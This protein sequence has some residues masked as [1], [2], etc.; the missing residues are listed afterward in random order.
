MKLEFLGVRNFFTKQDYHNNLLVDDHILIDCGFSAARSLAETG[1]S[2]ADVDSIFITHTHADHIGGLEEC[3]FFN[4][5]VNGGTRPRLFLPEALIPDLWKNSLSGGLANPGSGAPGID[6]YFDIQPVL[7]SFSTGGLNF[8][9][10]P[11]SHVPDK[12]CCGLM[13]ED[14]GYFSGDTQFAPETIQEYGNRAMAVF[15]E[16]EFAGGIV[17]ALRDDLVTVSEDIRQETWLMHYSDEVEQQLDKIKAAEFK[18]V[19][20]HTPYPF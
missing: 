7:E 15:H 2:F 9:I 13:I 14:K 4:R 3:A 11:T 19:E 20:S 18:L 6:A 5:Y 10:I 16:V 12:F 17:H 8:E 1:R